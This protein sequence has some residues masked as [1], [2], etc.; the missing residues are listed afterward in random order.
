MTYSIVARDPAGGALGVAVQSC[1]FNVGA[2]VPWPAAGVGAVATQAFADPAYG[3]RCLDALAAGASAAEALDKAAAADPAAS[4]RQVGVVGADGSVAA[5]TGAGCIDHAGHRTGDGFA[6]QANMMASPSV[7]PA[8]ADAYTSATGPLP[9]RLLAA[10]NAAQT[11]GGDARG[12]MSAALV[13]VGGTPGDGRLVDLRVDRSSDPLGELAR[14]LDAADAYNRFNRA[15]DELPGGDAQAALA[16]L[17]AGLAILPGDPNLQLLRTAAL[18]ARGDTDTGRQHLR[19]LLASH[20]TWEVIVR[21]YAARGLLPLP[22]GTS[23][24]ALSG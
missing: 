10:L 24:D 18:L 6:V 1:F 4:L 2:I 19:S 7:W 20:P 8:M 5:T 22:A 21:G 16:D 12:V 9:R 15:S 3:P 23:I 17:D 11:A 14:L 13:V